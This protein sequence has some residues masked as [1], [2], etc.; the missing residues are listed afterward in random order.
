M[1]YQLALQAQKARPVGATVAEMMETKA[2]KPVPKPRVAVRKSAVRA[3]GQ[4]RGWAHAG[5]RPGE[6][7]LLG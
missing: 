1:A 2:A 4:G 5:P 7:A 3:T 6:M